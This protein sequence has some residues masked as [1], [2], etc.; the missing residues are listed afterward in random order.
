M[1]NTLTNPNSDS[2]IEAARAFVKA[3]QPA[4]DAAMGKPFGHMHKFTMTNENPHS[5]HP[6]A[7]DTL[8]EMRP[9]G[10]DSHEATFKAL[11]SAW[12]NP[13][14]WLPAIPAANNAA[15]HRTPDAPAPVPT[16]R[17]DAF[18]QQEH[19]AWDRLWIDHSIQLE[20]ALATAQSAANDA[21]EY[22]ARMQR[23]R[24]DARACIAKRI[25]DYLNER[26]AD[27]GCMGVSPLE[28]YI[29]EEEGTKLAERDAEIARL[30]TEWAT[31]TKWLEQ[32]CDT[33]AADNARLTR[34]NAE[35][36]AI[37]YP[38][39]TAMDARGGGK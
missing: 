32:K 4:F 17:T 27:C 29:G 13:V 10:K 39:A 35:L 25:E 33:L 12:V 7:A 8:P 14:G 34:E 6:P 18:I 28:Q 31:R 24:D 30:N 38:T 36:R 20:T 5:T 1:S 9:R 11:E 19:V 3:V 37:A 15:I 23:E 26:D 16:P 22:G 21:R 2:L